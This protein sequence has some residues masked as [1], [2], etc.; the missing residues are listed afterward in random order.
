MS[1]DLV[2]IT[3]LSVVF[4][5]RHGEVR[6]V[7]GIS[8]DI[9]EGEKMAIL[10][11]SGCGK[12]VLALSLLG[13]LPR[14]ACVRGKVSIDGRETAGAARDMCGKT[15]SMCWSNAEKF[16]NPVMRVGEQI[17]EAFLAHHP[18]QR[19][20]GRQK[21]LEIMGSL[22]FHDPAT[23]YK[24]YP[25]QLSG[26]MNQR[27]MI[28]MSI[29]NSPR[30][31]IVDEPTRGLD[32]SSRERVIDAI[33]CLKGVT[34]MLITHDVDCALRLATQAYIMRRGVFIDRISIQ[35]QTGKYDNPYTSLLVGSCPHLWEPGRAWPSSGG[36]SGD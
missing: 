8:F 21:A 12:S 31:L 10:G 1:G 17:V 4:A 15:V 36:G 23:V 18:G 3:D 7:D 24:S 34:L 33:G 14:N 11:E 26:G 19:R 6:A 2:S 16:F 25:Y 35:E 32:D 22:G 28:A 27:A 20:M 30:L 13:I 29:I 5:T 9:R